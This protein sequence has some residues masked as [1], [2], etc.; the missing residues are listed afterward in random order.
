MSDT[1]TEAGADERETDEIILKLVRPLRV[2]N[3]MVSELKFRAPT[4][5][6]IVSIGNPVIFDLATDPPRITHNASRMTAMLA[7]LANIPTTSVTQLDP[8]DWVTAAWK[9]SGFFIPRTEAL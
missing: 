5:A 2:F 7:K 8:R 9:I 3:D 6:D 1:E 4:A